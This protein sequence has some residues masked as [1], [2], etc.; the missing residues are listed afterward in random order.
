M[1]KRMLPLALVVSALLAGCGDG[2]SGATT[3]PGTCGDAAD[4][5]SSI[6]GAQARSP[7]I[8]NSVTIEAVVVG[9]HVEGLGGIFVQEEQAD[10]DGDPMSSEGLFLQVDGASPRVSTG[11]VV[12][13]RG[14]V[15]ELGEG[16]RTL[17][18]LIEL[19]DFRVC[20]RAD[21]LPL[22]ALI[23]EAPLLRED[24]EAWEGMRVEIEPAATVVGNESVLARGELLVALGGR[25]WVPT[26]RHPPGEA[27]RQLA[28]DQERA[29]ILLDDGSV[30]GGV[31]ERVTW[32]R[33]QPSGDAPLRVGSEVRAIAGVLDERL[34]GYRIHVDGRVE[35]SQAPRPQTAPEV[36]GSLRIATFNVQNYFNGDGQ[37]G[38]FPTPRGART[39]EELK[40]QRAKVISALRGLDADLYALVE[41]ENDGYEKDSAI[42]ELAR[43]LGAS[44]GRPREYDYIRAPSERLG[45]DAI[46]V[47]FLYRT[48][49]LQPV[50]A[51]AAL[52]EGPFALGNRV[53]LAQTF[54]VRDSKGRFTAVVNHF[55]SKGGC[56]NADEANRD[57]GDGQG[58]FNAR[59]VEAAR[60]LA[61]WLATDPTNSGDPDVLIL[62]DLNA[63]SRED[64]IRLLEEAGYARAR[65]DAGRAGYTYVWAGLSGH[66]DHALMSAS[67][68]QQFRD[69][70]V[71]HINADEMTDFDFR[72]GDRPRAVDARMFRA[73]PFRSS[74]HD[75]LLLGF[76][77]APP[78]EP[79]PESRDEP[80][81][82]DA[83]TG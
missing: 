81:A 35:V 70:A 15:G 69:I 76:D 34:G 16:E 59:R 42:A 48:R 9:A 40:R 36:T 51:A 63:Y 44:K 71:W 79:A 61:N 27:A 80:A 23:E 56:E 2:P 6:Q 77:I 68:A 50:G 53:P 38:G 60:A 18:A 30:E 65:D 10:R 13:A 43:E 55:K 3:G 4:L 54:E 26:D 67:L 75:P 47:G 74:D 64:P 21:D 31:P 14:V 41:V 12:R 73:D 49:K 11:D 58:C 20:G 82:K 33:E 19:S 29:R 5:I 8:G 28:A 66:L 17:T 78:P 45:S 52:G 24:W 37:G 32:L 22:P 62:G 25:Q 46:S 57:R 1:K 72:R 7:R 83:P 39:A